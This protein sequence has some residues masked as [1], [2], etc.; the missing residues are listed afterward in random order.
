[1]LYCNKAVNQGQCTTS[2]GHDEEFLDLDKELLEGIHDEYLFED[3]Y[4]VG[5]GTSFQDD[6]IEKDEDIFEVNFNVDI[7]N[8]TVTEAEEDIF[9]SNPIEEVLEL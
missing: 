8:A 7:F 6:N 4:T 3:P 1:M 5:N 9:G 2:I